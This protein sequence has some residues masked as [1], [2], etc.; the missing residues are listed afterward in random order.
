MTPTP[1]QLVR[2]IKTAILD[3]KR[4]LGIKIKDSEVMGLAEFVYEKIMELVS[5]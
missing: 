1:E 5:K 4:E 3:H 2:T